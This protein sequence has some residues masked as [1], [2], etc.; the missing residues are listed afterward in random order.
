M[1]ELII[2]YGIKCKNVRCHVFIGGCKT[3]VIHQLLIE[4]IL[5][6][7]SAAGEF[8][9]RSTTQNASLRKMG[10]EYV[11]GQLDMCL[12]YKFL[13]WLYTTHSHTTFFLSPYWINIF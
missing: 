9:Q 11:M 1:G 2:E 13:H 5:N 4:C 6:S 12:T 7:E 10:C 8:S 3:R